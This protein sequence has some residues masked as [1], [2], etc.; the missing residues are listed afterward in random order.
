MKTLYEVLNIDLAQE[1]TKERKLAVIKANATLLG[2][3]LEAEA[4]A[5]IAG[6]DIPES[7][8]RYHWIQKIGRAAGADLLTLGKVQPETMLAMAALGA[9]DFKEAVKVA[10]GTARKLN[11]MT[12]EAE[13]ELNQETL[14]STMV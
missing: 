5:A 2:A 3:D 8:E 11:Q 9:D 14:P 12:V 4:K 1:Y 10:T 6:M 7:D 13:K